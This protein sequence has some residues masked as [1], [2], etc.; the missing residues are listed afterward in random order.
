[1]KNGGESLLLNYYKFGLMSNFL[2]DLNDF[3]NCNS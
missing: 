1:M 2:I 3:S